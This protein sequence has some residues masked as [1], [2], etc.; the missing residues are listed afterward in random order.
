[1]SRLPI[2][3]SRA[4]Q[5]PSV[6]EPSLI[7]AKRPPAS[8]SAPEPELGKAYDARL[9]R[10]LLSYMR[11][12]KAVVAVSLLFLLVNAVLTGMRA[13]RAPASRSPATR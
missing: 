9:M 12:Y 8:S 11:P 1:M 10:R 2:G 13:L 5:A 4:V 7:M 3:R 6:S